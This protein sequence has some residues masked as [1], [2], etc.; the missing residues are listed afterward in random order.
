MVKFNWNYPTTMWIGKDRIKD[1]PTACLTL[2]VKKPL[3]VTDKNLVKTKLIDNLIE[4]L[5]SKKEQ[6]NI[7]RNKMRVRKIKKK[8][9]KEQKLK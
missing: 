4:I 3:L 8:K 9:I 6:S 2:N 5:K 1:L 7:S